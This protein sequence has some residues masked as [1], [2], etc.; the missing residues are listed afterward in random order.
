[1][2]TDERGF[3]ERGKAE[4]GK[5]G[6]EKLNHGWARMNADLVEGGRREI[7]N[8]G[9]TGIRGKKA[10]DFTAVEHRAAWENRVI[11]LVSPE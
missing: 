3:G 9:I 6:K 8:H 10:G 7:L 2:D 4:T 5:A 11:Q 1:M